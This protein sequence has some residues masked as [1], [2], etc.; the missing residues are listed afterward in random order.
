MS[1]TK[2]N[3]R[4]LWISAINKIKAE[5]KDF[6]DNDNRTCRELF[7]LTLTLIDVDNSNIE[8]PIKT[9]IDSKKWVYPAKEELSSII[10]KEY[11][12][13]IYEYTYGGRIFNFNSELD[14]INSFILPLLK[15]D[16]QTRRAILVFYDPV[17][18]S[19]PDHKNT[20]GI[21]YVQFRIIDHKLHMTCHIR[22]NDLFFGW[23]ANTYQLYCLMNFVSKKL[24]IP[25]GNITTFSNSAH[26]FTEDLPEI[27]EIIKP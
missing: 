9:M 27:E 11:H 14:Q 3:A 13:P 24:E 22:S 20:P 12:A 19:K 17:E 7:N 5:G 1:I 26:I 23:P 18:D 10:F 2:N 15:K 6:V 4:E 16:P 21:I 8:K 25:N